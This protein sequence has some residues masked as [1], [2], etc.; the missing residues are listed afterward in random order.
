M[1]RKLEKQ[2]WEK[3]F[4]NVSKNL[5]ARLVEIEVVNEEIGD[6][7][8][9]EAQPL[10]GLSYDP[11]DDEFVVEAEHHTHIIPKPK[12]IYVEEDIDGLKLVEVIKEDGEKEIIRIKTPQSLK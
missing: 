6:Q 2:E 9:T 5:G 12:E 3:F 8:E 4:D 7:V 1:V 11:K 10:V